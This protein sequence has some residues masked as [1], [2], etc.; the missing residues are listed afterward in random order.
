M[1]GGLI[2]EQFQ[3]EGELY[4]SEKRVNKIH[5]RFRGFST[6]LAHFDVL[7]VQLDVRLDF[8]LFGKHYLRMKWPHLSLQIIT[9]N[10]MCLII[11]LFEFDLFNLTC[12]SLKGIG[13]S[14]LYLV[15]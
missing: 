9:P 6:A 3:S 11:S 5:F 13:K 8:F 15:L 1:R 10:V 4:S 12:R 7:C 2:A 14:Q